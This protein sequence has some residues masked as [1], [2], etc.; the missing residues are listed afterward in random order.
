M[1]DFC[2]TW[3]T[4][5]ICGKDWYDQCMAPRRRRDLSTELYA[6]DVQ[7]EQLYA[8]DADAKELYT[9]WRGMGIRW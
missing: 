5:N 9:G 6:R 4:G 2:V 1:K 3:S 7:E 8:R